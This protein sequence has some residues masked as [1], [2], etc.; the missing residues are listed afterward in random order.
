MGALKMELRY[1]V[2]TLEKMHL[3]VVLVQR[4]ESAVSSELPLA[5]GKLPRS[6]FEIKG[7]Q[8]RQELMLV[9]AAQAKRECKATTCCRALSQRIA[10]GAFFLIC[11]LVLGN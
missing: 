11:Q 1:G 5:T 7:R 8:M 4:C 10:G 2:A 9:V 6:T 3:S